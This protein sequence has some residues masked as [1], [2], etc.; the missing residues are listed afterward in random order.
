MEY[1]S[2]EKSEIKMQKSDI[3]FSMLSQFKA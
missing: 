2:D 3:I 1:R